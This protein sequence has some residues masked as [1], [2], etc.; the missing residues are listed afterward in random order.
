MTEKSVSHI[1]AVIEKRGIDSWWTDAEDNPAWTPPG[2]LESSGATMYR[3]GI[4]TM[5][6]W[7]DSGTSWTL[8][9]RD[10]SQDTRPLS[11][12]YIE[13][14][15]Q[16]RAGESNS[17]DQGSSRGVIPRTMVP[18][19]AMVLSDSRRWTKRRPARCP[20]GHG[21]RHSGI[22]EA[23]LPGWRRR[24]GVCALAR[25]EGVVPT[26]LPRAVGGATEGGLKRGR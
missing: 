14:S 2:L 4:D 25:R 6:V 15:D 16:H 17:H 26:A 9:K 11:D 13:G 22:R 20:S 10:R 19:L 8:L 21:R 3:R 7:F 12:V 1:M 5:D 24:T 18:L 23:P